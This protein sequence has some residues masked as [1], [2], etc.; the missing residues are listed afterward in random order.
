MIFFSPFTSV[1]VSA[2]SLRPSRLMRQCVGRKARFLCHHRWCKIHL[3]E[4]KYVY[5]HLIHS[6]HWFIAY[7][8][9]PIKEVEKDCVITCVFVFF[10][11]PVFPVAEGLTPNWSFFTS[12]VFFTGVPLG[13]R[14]M[15]KSSSGHLG[16]M[17]EVEQCGWGLDWGTGSGKGREE[18]VILVGTE[19][20]SYSSWSFSP[21]TEIVTK[22]F[23]DI[24]F[25]FLLTEPN[26]GV[27]IP[28][29]NSSLGLFF[30]FL[31][32]VMR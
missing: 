1:V 29:E 14:V 9:V 3:K 8:I 20:F 31:S 2:V 19:S 7:A 13:L 17:I 30:F 4:I 5:R 16:T 18:E 6:F 12:G 11:L 15:D 25:Q 22:V 21:L 10:F 26:W 28:S 27:G 23:T 24:Y 32:V